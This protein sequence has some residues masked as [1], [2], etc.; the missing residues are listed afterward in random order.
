MYFELQLSQKVFT[1]FV[2]NR[3]KALP[4]CVDRELT[5]ADG[6]R[7]V[8]DQ[9]VI[10]ETTLIQ[11]EQKIEVVDGFPKPKDI[12]TQGVWILSPKNLFNV[13]VPFLQVKQEVLIHLVKSSDLDA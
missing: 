11:R 6:N 10:G 4:L 9:V 8:V 2:R 1:R 13:T 12:A 3:L 7:L 5:D